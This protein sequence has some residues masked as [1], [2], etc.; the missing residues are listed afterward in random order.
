MRRGC[1]RCGRRRCGPAGNLTAGRSTSTHAVALPPTVTAERLRRDP[2]VRQLTATALTIADER[3]IVTLDTAERQA[4]HLT[5]AWD[6]AE[7]L[8]Q[9]GR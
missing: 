8:A 7:Q 4:A 1:S 3:T 5:R 9:L 6:A 2:V